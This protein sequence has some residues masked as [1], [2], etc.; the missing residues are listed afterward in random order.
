MN[1]R[2]GGSQGPSVVLVGP[3]RSGKT[4][5][6]CALLHNRKCSN[7]LSE[8]KA[9]FQNPSIS[10]APSDDDSALRTFEILSDQHMAILSGADFAI[11]ASEGVSRFPVQLTWGDTAPSNGLTSF[12]GGGKDR[13]GTQ[14]FIIVDGRGGDIASQQ[15]I[16]RDD[17]V[18]YDRLEAYRQAIQEA[19]G[20]ILCMST[21]TDDFA[22]KEAKGLEREI[23][24]ALK[25][26][27]ERRKG[28]VPLK[29][30]SICLMKYERLFENAPGSA[31]YLA[32]D[33]NNLR[34][35]FKDSGV[36]DFFKFL[37]SRSMGPDAFSVRI[38]PN[39][40]YGFVDGTGAPNFY[41]YRYAPGLLTRVVDPDQY[42]DT[43]LPNLQ[44]H[45]PVPVNQEL[46]QRY[47]VPFNIAPP[48]IYALS[49][50]ETGPMFL[51]PEELI[52]EKEQV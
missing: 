23:I 39:S 25:E 48:V 1:A 50:R 35:L 10:E 20:M 12:L 36:V 28:S 26:K 49:G 38:F 47:W 6:L 11:E 9:P 8:G 52:F 2:T 44:E 4:N 29:H 14:N 41:P 17:K 13:S 43:D 16:T 34:E 40:T 27:R 24:R 3:S 32:R 33:P 18:R 42:D 15:P 21:D 19:T 51:R 5:L 30:I 45:F 37:I 46:A 7:D 31:A 22:V